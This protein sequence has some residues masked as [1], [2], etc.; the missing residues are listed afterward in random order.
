V[1][2]VLGSER[3]GLSQ[4]MRALASVSL[5]IDS[6]G[7]VDSLNLASAAAVMMYEVRRQ[8]SGRNSG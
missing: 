5:R 3:E 7:H 1:A 6:G 4:G 8:R 2:L